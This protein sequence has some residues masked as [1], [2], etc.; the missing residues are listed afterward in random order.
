MITEEI[1]EQIRKELTL[2]ALKNHGKVNS[3]TILGVMLSQNAEL[4]KDIPSLRGVIAEIA[5]EYSQKS[6]DEIKELAKKYEVKVEEKKK[7]RKGMVELQVSSNYR[8]RIP[9]EP[10]KHLHI[11]HALSFLINYIYAQKYKGSVV[12][13]FEDTNPELSKQ[14]YVDSIKDDILNYLKIKPAEISFASDNMELFYEKSREL[15]RTED[16]YVCTCTK[17]QISENRMKMQECECRKRSKED[18]ETMLNAMI[19]NK[20][21]KG[22]AVLRLKGDMQSKNA[23]MR[24]PILIRISGKEHYKYGNKYTAWP[25]YDLE[26]SIMDGKEGVTHI[27]RSNEFGTMREQLQKFLKEKLG[28]ALPQVHQYGRFNIKDAETKGREIRKGIEEG[29]FIGWDDPRLATLKTMKRRG[30]LADTFYEIAREVGL[31]P[32]PTTVDWKMIEKYNRRFVDK[33][34][35][36]YSFIYDPVEISVKGYENKEVALKYHPD[37][38]KAER[39]FYTNGKFLVRK[40]DL[41]DYFR[42]MDAGNIKKEGNDYIL[43]S[44]NIEDFRKNNGK[45]IINWLPAD[46]TQSIDA[47]IMMPNASIL[48]GKVEKRILGSKIGDIVQLERFGFCRIDEINNNSIKLWYGHK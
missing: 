46:E 22:K 29:Q 8:G 16:A 33:T 15:V 2:N 4:K 13:R 11:G 18:N 10:S 9:P 39:T 1:K 35:K 5:E 12:L 14:E 43:E 48:E 40:E 6:F 23:V 37:A 41:Q 3:G 28:Y 25:V 38:K 34:S 47:E 32:S 19:E 45:N 30:I 27:L 36:R 7:E 44:D 26:N 42:L 31:S 21:E 17:E 20:T 24:D